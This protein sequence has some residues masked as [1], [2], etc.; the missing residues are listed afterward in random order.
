MTA[1]LIIP[2]N[3]WPYKIPDLN[4]FLLVSHTI[5]CFIFQKVPLWEQL[6]V[7]CPH[8]LL[9]F[10]V[11]HIMI[12]KFMTAVSN[13]KIVSSM[14]AATE[15]DNLVPCLRATMDFLVLSLLMD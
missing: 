15:A 13:S 2:A 6:F 3:D 4:I 11:H 7:G 9:T 5:N 1:F 12:I 10:V 8:F 14:I